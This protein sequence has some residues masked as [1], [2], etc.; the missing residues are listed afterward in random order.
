MDFWK[1][2]F[3]YITQ[4][5]SAAVIVIL[6][7]L[8][9]LLLW[10]I[11]AVRAHAHSI[12]EKLDNANDKVVLAK[13]KEIDSIKEIVEK[14][15]NGTLTTIQALNEIKIVLVSIKESIR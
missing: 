7:A 2:V 12:N 15:Q 10:E 6:V 4:G 11:K 9:V 14:Y 5:G 13:E 3:E 1:V 8:N